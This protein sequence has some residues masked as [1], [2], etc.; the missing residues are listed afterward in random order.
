M[1]KVKEYLIKL[2][3]SK[4]AGPDDTLPR[5]LKELAQDTTGL[6]AISF[7]NTWRTG[8]IPEGWRKQM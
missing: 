7:E 6:L 5:P 3:I 8:E 4:S 2:H 1:E